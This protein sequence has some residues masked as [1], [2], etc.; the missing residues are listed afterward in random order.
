M[1][2]TLLLSGDQRVRFQTTFCLLTLVVLS[3]CGGSAGPE[4]VPAT[5]TVIFKD[6]PIAGATVQMI[7]EKGQNS[8]GFTD[9]EGKFR[10]TTGGRP[11]VPVGKAKVGITKPTNTAANAP[12]PKAVKPEDMMSMQKA[13]GG[14]AK[15]LTTKSEIPEKYQDPNKSKLEAQ[16][17]KDGKK[18]V[19]EFVLVE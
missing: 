1:T 16:I 18:N 12:D 14:V 9:P 10:M 17:D 6:K 15:E 4:L 5:G 2:P 11:G 8:T 3:G 7:S 13:G 19:F